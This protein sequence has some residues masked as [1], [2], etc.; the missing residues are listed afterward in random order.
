MSNH[1]ILVVVSTI[2]IKY[3]QLQ[4][5][6][7]CPNHRVTRLCFNH[8]RLVDL[9]SY[10]SL[11]MSFLALFGALFSTDTMLLHE[12]NTRHLDSLV[13]VLVQTV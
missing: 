5:S 8:V 11:H 9:S 3:L 6:G 7:V 13:F 10:L 4:F 2:Y 1:P 12:L